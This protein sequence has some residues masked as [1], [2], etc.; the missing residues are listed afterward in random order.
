LDAVKADTLAILKIDDNIEEYHWEVKL[1]IDLQKEIQVIHTD[2]MDYTRHIGILEGN[3]QTADKTIQILQGLITTAPT[4]QAI[5]LPHPPKYSR[6]RK[7]LLNFI[8][9]VCSKLAGENC[10]FS[11]NQHKL[12]Y[13]YSYLKGNTQNQI[14]PYIQ[15]DNISLEDVKALI[16]ILKATFS[17]PNE[18][19]MASGE[20]D[21]LT[22][23][24]YKFSIYYAEFQSLMAILDYDSKVKK[25]TLKQ[26]LSKELQASLMYR[27]DE[28][29]DFDKFVELCMILYYRI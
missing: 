12:R 23:G 13:V 14:Q 24:N 5:E 6:D 8:S 19:G 10:Y 21:Y 11:D 3:L 18:V 7:D 29:K 17:N 9:K 16:N 26:G 28:P 27:T 25:A 15:T 2:N 22:Q 20:L 1:I 4:L